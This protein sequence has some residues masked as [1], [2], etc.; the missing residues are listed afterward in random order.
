MVIL[1]PFMPV[2]G[3]LIGVKRYSKNK[4]MVKEQVKAD[5]KAAQEHGGI[6]SLYYK[7]EGKRIFTKIFGLPVMIGFI[8]GLLF[9]F[10]G[11]YGL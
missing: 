6:A 5:Y 11:F 3:I 8:V 2:L 9:M 4:D 10:I 1:G 7:H